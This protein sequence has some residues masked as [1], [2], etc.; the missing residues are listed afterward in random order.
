MRQILPEEFPST[1]LEK[2]QPVPDIERRLFWGL[3]NF[4][5]L[6][7]TPVSK[8]RGDRCVG[9]SN[10]YTVVVFNLGVLFAKG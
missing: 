8:L 3:P 5:P 10:N 1:P 4:L 6:F 7:G 2:N 9:S